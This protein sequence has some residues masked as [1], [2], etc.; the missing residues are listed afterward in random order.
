MVSYLQE[1]KTYKEEETVSTTISKKLLCIIEGKRELKY[2]TRIFTIFKSMQSCY[3]LTNTKIKIAWGNRFPMHINLVDESCNFQGGSLK[4]SPVPTPAI[5]AFEMYKT[6]LSFYDGIIVIFDGDKDKN[7]IVRNYFN[8]QF[9]YIG[10]E[11]CLVISDPCFESTLIDYCSCGNCKSTMLSLPN[12]AFP[13][14][15][16]KNNFS[17]L[18][19]FLNFTNSNCTNQKI[20]SKGLITFLDMSNIINLKSNV[21]Q[22]NPLNKLIENFISKYGA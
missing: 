8:A 3:D 1:L 18:N 9:S 17:S 20:T 10:I 13:C 12:E 11:M 5:E 14:D 6:N 7:N 21:S 16:Y 2:I 19:C 15:K 4:N 22:L